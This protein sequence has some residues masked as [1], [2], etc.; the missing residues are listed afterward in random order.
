MILLWLIV[1]LILAIIIARLNESNKLFWVAF[2]SFAIGI[3]IESIA[4][5]MG[6]S[7]DDLTQAYPTQVVD[8]TLSMN[9]S[10]ADVP[11]TTQSLVP[12]PVSQ[13]STPDYSENHLTLSKRNV[14]PK[15]EPPDYD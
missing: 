6:Q 8:S 10:L 12:N 13:D 4:N 7:K 5:K 14:K 9:S 3:A 11:D 1:A 15:T 2:M